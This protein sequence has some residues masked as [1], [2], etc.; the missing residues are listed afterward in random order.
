MLK[1]SCRP[2]D[3]EVRRYVIDIRDNVI[4]RKSAAERDLG[5]CQVCH[6]RLL[7]GMLVATNSLVL[8]PVLINAQPKS[9]MPL[10]SVA[11]RGLPCCRVACDLLRNGWEGRAQILLCSAAAHAQF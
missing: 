3:A 8:L 5:V 2:F 9:S 7:Q 6:T 10:K 1:I 11:Q 4:W